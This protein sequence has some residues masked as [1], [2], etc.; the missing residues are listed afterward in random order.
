[1]SLSVGHL[2]KGWTTFAYYFFQSLHSQDW[3]TSRLIG[4]ITDLP[5]Y[6]TA[7]L[8]PLLRSAV[9]MT[10]SLRSDL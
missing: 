2:G 6:V 8:D 1:M 3:L 9:G 7:R 5:I 4:L 10:H